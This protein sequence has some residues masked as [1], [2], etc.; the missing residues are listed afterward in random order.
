MYLAECKHELMHTYSDSSKTL[1]ACL[2]LSSVSL[3]HSVCIIH[4]NNILHYI[5]LCM[6]VCTGTPSS[7]LLRTDAASNVLIYMSGHGGDGF[8]KFQDAEEICS[9]DIADAFA[10]MHLKQRYS[11]LLL[12]V[13]TCQAGSLFGAIAAPNVLCLGS[14]ALG[15]NSYAHHVDQE[16]AVPTMD[17]FTA[18]TLDFFERAHADAARAS[19]SSTSSSGSSSSSSTSSSTVAESVTLQQLLSSYDPRWL[20]SNPV[21]DE[22][23]WPRP[24]DGSDVPVTDF[25]G[26]VLDVRLTHDLYYIEPCSADDCDSSSGRSSSSDSDSVDGANATAAQ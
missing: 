12:V 5:A 3:H 17:R 9:Q 6:P 1:G 2:S 8:L 23:N 24:L 20:K 11:E 19:G 16:L 26:S 10:D 21:V 7:K 15:E 25:F 22:R 18:V 13:D 4:I 14:S